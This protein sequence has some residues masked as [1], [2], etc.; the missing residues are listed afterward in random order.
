MISAFISIRFLDIIDILLVAFLM[1]KI[2]FLIKDTAAINIFIGIFLL[3]LVW[4]VVLAFNMELIGTILGQIIGVGV[5]ALIIV[6]Q[7]EIRRFLL[8]LG[9][10]YASKSPFSLQRLFSG[11]VIRPMV[12][13]NSIIR[14]CIM[15]SEKKIGALIVIARQSNLSAIAHTGEIIDCITSSRMLEAIF[16]KDNP[17]HDGA[18][19]IIKDRIHAAACILPLTE[20]IYIPPQYGLRH[21]AALGISE[22][23]DA[24]VVIVSEERGEI[25]VAENGRMTNN[26]SIR[27]LMNYLEKKFKV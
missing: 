9:S 5:I 25:S 20:N 23:S 10:Q 17:L 21:R 19:I 22:I 2:Y 15:F 16:F 11:T 27:E 14:A 4:L 13:I 1:Y 6:F 7:Q 24:I 8:L 12:R 18:V 26:M 3:Y